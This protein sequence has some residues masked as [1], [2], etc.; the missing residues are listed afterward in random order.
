MKKILVGVMV[1]AMGLVLAIG[2]EKA[3]VTEEMQ[4]QIVSEMAEDTMTPQKSVSAATVVIGNKN[5][6]VEVAST[7]EERM[8]G[9]GGRD[10][11]SPNTGMWFVF[12]ADSQ[13]PFWM[14][15]T[16]FNL[17]M[18]FVGDDMKIKDLK[19][20]NVAMT[21][22]LIQPA[23]PYRYVLEVNAGEGGGLSVGD[24]VNY[25]VGP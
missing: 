8:K 2:C 9:L 7:D 14:K 6:T 24:T 10:S 25:Q 18:V 5:W 20:N 23:S 16:K 1:I 3:Q 22:T 19:L 17:D 12:P 11:L 4:E 21:D 13:D 15:D